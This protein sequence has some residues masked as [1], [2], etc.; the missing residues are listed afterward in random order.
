MNHIH[1]EPSKFAGKKVRIKQEVVHPQFKDFGGSEFLV[2]DWWDRVAGESWMYCEGNPACL[3]YAVRSGLL[4][5]PIDNE[6]LYG[7]VGL[8]GHLVHI[9]EICINEKR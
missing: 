4:G 2:E 7:K 9:S 5:L 8:Y 3:T 6:V 1:P